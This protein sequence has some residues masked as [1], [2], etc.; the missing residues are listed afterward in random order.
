MPDDAAADEFTTEDE[1]AFFRELFAPLFAPFAPLLLLKKFLKLFAP[2]FPEFL[3]LLLKGISE[4]ADGTADDNVDVAEFTAVVVEVIAEF[5]AEFTLPNAE[6]TAV[7]NVFETEFAV[8]A[9][10]LA[11]ALRVLVELNIELILCIIKITNEP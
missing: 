2:E 9:T 3:W 11:A 4:F 7:V 6:F 10:E 5:T 1:F 8:F